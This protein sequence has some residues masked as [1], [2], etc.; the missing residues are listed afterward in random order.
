MQ[1]PQQADS[2]MAP[3]SMNLST[4]PAR[5]AFMYSILLAGTT[6]MRTPL[7]TGSPFIIWEAKSRSSK[8]PLVH[9]PRKT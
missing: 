1:G 4:N 9:E 5:S 8:R 7:A 3:A 6:I 2:T